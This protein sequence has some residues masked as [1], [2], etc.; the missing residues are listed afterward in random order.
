MSDVPYWTDKGSELGL[1]EKLFVNFYES[2][3]VWKK[4]VEKECNG[5]IL[6][7]DMGLGK[8]IMII[9]LILANR[10]SK[11]CKTLIIVPLSVIKQWQ[12]QI[13]KFAP[14]LRSFI[15]N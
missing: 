5:G 2:W 7:D 15:A 9:A 6:A 12:D 13:K 1:K 10:P 11:D 14:H 8:T 4:I 3:V